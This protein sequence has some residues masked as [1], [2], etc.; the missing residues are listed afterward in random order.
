MKEVLGSISSKD[1]G[2]LDVDSTFV[3]YFRTFFL[4][5]LLYGKNRKKPQKKR[6]DSRKNDFWHYGLCFFNVIQK[7]LCVE[8]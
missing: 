5:E 8:F 2:K 6:I 1:K 7:V 4:I 3:S